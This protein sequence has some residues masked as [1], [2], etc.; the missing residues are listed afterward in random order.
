MA[1]LWLFNQM[2][3]EGAEL[4]QICRNLTSFYE[5]HSQDFL[6]NTQEN[7]WAV[8]TILAGADVDIQLSFC[9]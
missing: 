4:L 3:G 2:E 6:Q 5:K 7:V 9:Y 8:A 1:K